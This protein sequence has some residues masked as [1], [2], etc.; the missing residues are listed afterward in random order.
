MGSIFKDFFN[1]GQQNNQPGGIEFIGEAPD[2][3]EQIKVNIKV[4]G[5]VQ[6]VGFRFTSK[7]AADQ[8]GVSGIVRNESDG[9]VY[10]EAVGTKDQVEEFIHALAKG[11]SPAA[12]VERVVVEYDEDIHDHQGF[13]QTN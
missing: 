7:Q 5:R 4:Y 10:A 13:S 9:S 3:T 2:S 6:G 8:I 12:T 1:K 11:P